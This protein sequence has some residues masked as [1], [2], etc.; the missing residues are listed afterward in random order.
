[1]MRCLFT[2]T[3]TSA[4]IPDSFIKQLANSRISKYI[5]TLKEVNM[6]FIP[7]EQQVLQV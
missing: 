6:A 4:V 5:R 7:Y 1:M 2:L 3:I